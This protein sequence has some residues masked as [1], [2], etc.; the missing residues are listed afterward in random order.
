MNW[1]GTTREG[2]NVAIR[3]MSVGEDGKEQMRILRRIARGN[4]SLFEEN[5]VAPLWREVA[6]G[7]LTFA[8]C[9]F[10]GYNMGQC[11]GY[12]AKDS[13]GDIIDMIMQALEVREVRWNWVSFSMLC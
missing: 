1:M 8:I 12:W 10:V 3:I 5:H 11:Y 6:I 7:D 13:V 9:P 4:I 2:H